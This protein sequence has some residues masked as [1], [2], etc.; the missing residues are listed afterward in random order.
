MVGYNLTPHNEGAV[1]N[2]GREVYILRCRPMDVTVLVP[3]RCASLKVVCVR[4]KTLVVFGR[5][6]SH[7]CALKAAIFAETL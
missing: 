2:W 3:N 1:R 5:E 6:N 7:F 4:H